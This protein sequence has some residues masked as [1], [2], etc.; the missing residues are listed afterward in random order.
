MH[1]H[2]THAQKHA[3]SCQNTYTLSRAGL[4]LCCPDYAFAWG[5]EAGHPSVGDC[6]G[7]GRHQ[8]LTSQDKSAPLTP[9]RP[10]WVIYRVGCAECG[11]CGHSEGLLEPETAPGTVTFKCSLYSGPRLTAGS[12]H[13]R[14]GPSRSDLGCQ[15]RVPFLRGLVPEGRVK[16]PFAVGRM[17]GQM[18]RGI[19][20]EWED[21][22][23]SSEDLHSHPLP[24]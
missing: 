16:C 2:H 11:Q 10:S 18:E 24:T 23:L 7:Q 17:T 5:L 13:G 1:I 6:S 4:A 8:K 19:S 9:W 22:V 15:D 14:R 20:M 21:P 12:S 3:Q